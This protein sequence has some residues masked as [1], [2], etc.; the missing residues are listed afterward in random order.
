VIPLDTL[1]VMKALDTQY[2]ETM[3]WNTVIP[4]M[5]RAETRFA[6]R[7]TTPH[8]SQRYA[9]GYRMS[10]AEI[11]TFIAEETEAARAAGVH[12]LTIRTHGRDEPK[13]SRDALL[14]A[15]FAKEEPSVQHFIAPATLFENVRHGSRDPALR[16]SELTREHEIEDYLPI[17]KECFLGQDQQRYVDDYKA[18]IRR[19]ERG[20][21]FFACYDGD[22]PVASGYMFHQPGFPMALLCGGA[23]RTAWRKRGAY[24]SLIAVR[25]QA[26]L[27]ANVQTLCVDASPQSAPILQRLGFIANDEVIFFEKTFPENPLR[28]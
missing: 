20:V 4:N 15:G 27:D 3:R 24:L 10:G 12:A 13:G 17:W 6:A 11:A 5:V 7:Y 28:V 26:A 19:G 2:F 9:L 16:V 18:I 8:L 22:E 25:A 14:A 1:S 21:R 23:T